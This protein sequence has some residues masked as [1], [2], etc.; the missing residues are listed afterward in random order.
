M[1]FLMLVNPASARVSIQFVQIDSR[2]SRDQISSMP[3]EANAIS[4]VTDSKQKFYHIC[5]DIDVKSPEESYQSNTSSW[6][7]FTYIDCNRFYF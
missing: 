7:D 6:N 2:I 5:C 3:L 1:L 4:F